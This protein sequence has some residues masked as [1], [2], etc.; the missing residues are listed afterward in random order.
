M[1][2]YCDTEGLMKQY[3]AGKGCTIQ[4]LGNNLDPGFPA[5]AYRI[6]STN[7][8]FCQPVQAG[9]EMNTLIHSTANTEITNPQLKKLGTELKQTLRDAGCFA[10]A[11][12]AQILHMLLVVLVYVGAYLVL[13][14]Q[15]DTMLRLF[16]L[17]ILAFI[18]VQAGYIAHEAGHGAITRHRWLAVS[19]G[20]FFNTFLTALCYSHFQKIHVCH[21]AHTNERDEDVD[22][23]SNLFSLYPEARAKNTSNWVGRIIT[24]YQAYLIWPL[25]SLQGFTLKIDSLKTLSQN[26]GKTRIDQII[27]VLHLFLWFGVPIYMLGPA[28]ATLNYFLM[29]W[30]IGPYLGAVFLV[31]HIGTHVIQPEEKMPRFIKQLVSTRNLG[32]SVVEDIIFGGL[33]NHIE[34]HLFPSIPS[35]RLRRARKIVR[36]FCQLNGLVYREMRWRK[37]AGEVFTYLNL[38]AR[39]PVA[40]AV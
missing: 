12:L 29:T 10:H 33:N 34:H 26:P 35:Y 4:S 32:D 14:Q 22:L 37:A 19:I 28:D 5:G 16:A 20:Q 18:S 17:F 40:G 39:E 13:L 1:V 8:Y 36:E 2:L 23:Q 24:R 27:L 38:V 15:P 11:P 25:V 6:V 3:Y 9:I 21:H 30:F 7:R 31:N